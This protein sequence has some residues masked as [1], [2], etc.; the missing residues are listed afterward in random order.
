MFRSLLLAAAG[1]AVTVGLVACGGD[2]QQGGAPPPPDVGVE[3]VKAQ[4]VPLSRDLVGRV[5]PVRASDV[6]ARVPGVLKR[7]TYEEGTDVTAGQILF[8]IDP[9]PFRAAVDAAEAGLAQA[10][11]TAKNAHVL[12]E[13]LRSVAR[14][15]YVSR[16]DLDNAEAAERSSAAAVQQA[17][18]NV[19]TARINLGYAY[20]RSPI[21]GRAGQQ[22]VTVGALVGQTEPT[23]LTTVEQLDPMWVNLDQPASEFLELQRAAA[24]GKVTLAEPNRARLQV[25]APDGTAH[26]PPGTLDFSGVVVDPATGALSLRGSVP[27]PDRSL[28]PGMFVNARLIIGTLNRAFLVPQASVQRDGQGPYV[29]VVGPENKVVQKRVTIPATSGTNW[30]VTAGLEDGDAVVVQGIQRAMIGAVVNPVA[31]DAG[32]QTAEKPAQAAAPSGEAGSQ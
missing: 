24:A 22:R 1:V 6:R 13:R 18:A 9:A 12:A 19:E 30:I 2:S 29:L 7:R 15:G 27:N 25:L 5:S 3:R 23:L 11:A 14:A 26:G 32:A 21:A 31:Q 8:E 4:P 10:E 16:T 17:R 28:L 20:V